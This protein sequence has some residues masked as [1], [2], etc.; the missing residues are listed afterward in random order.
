MKIA[1]VGNTSFSM[2]VFRNHIMQHLSER[3]VDVYCIAP[4]DSYTETIVDM[5]IN[6][7]EL[8]LDRKG[9]NPVKDFKLYNFLKKLYAQERF[10]LILHYTIKPN[11]YGTLAAN[12]VGIKSV[13]FITGLGYTFINNNLTSLIAKSL[14]KYSLNKANKVYFLNDQD[15]TLFLESNIVESTKSFLMPGE[16]VNTQRFKLVQKKWEEEVHYIFVGR[17]LLDKGISELLS[18]FK[19][20]T[21]ESKKVFLHIVGDVDPEYR[22]SL[23]KEEFIAEIKTEDNIFYHGYQKNILPYLEKAHY[24]ILPSYREGLSTVTIEAMSCS[25]P[26]LGSDVPGINN[27]IIHDKNGFLFEAK[28][29]ESLRNMILKS[30]DISSEEYIILSKNARSRIEQDFSIQRILQFYENNIISIE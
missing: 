21:K 26:V 20:I 8:P 18:A 3:E 11:I 17:L 19:A 6:Y 12:K 4:P 7:I 9:A 28:S 23:T 27:I 22:L 14:Y 10:D 15:R 2:Y 13:A 29:V 30:S 25:R 16:G 5:G 24:L 1:F